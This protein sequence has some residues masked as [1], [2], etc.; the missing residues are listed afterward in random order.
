[1]KKRLVGL[2]AVGSAALVLIGLSV[3]GLPGAAAEGNQTLHFQEQATNV[4]YVPVQTLINSHQSG[5]QGDYVVFEDPL[6]NDKQQVVGYNEGECFTTNPTTGTS[7]CP[8]VTFVFTG[9]HGFPKGTIQG[10]GIFIGPP[11]GSQGPANADPFL[12][13]TGAFTGAQGTLTGRQLSFTLDDWTLSYS[14]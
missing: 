3:T 7:E 1:M 10:A 2:T 12:Y 5:N 14:R 6:V 9:V 4:T 13:G 11:D 8:G